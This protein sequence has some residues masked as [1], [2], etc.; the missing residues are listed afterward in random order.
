MIA[1]V[2]ENVIL[3]T[4]EF[5]GKIL[6]DLDKLLLSKLSF[7]QVYF[8]VKS[9]VC[10]LRINNYNSALIRICGYDTKAIFLVTDINKSV[11]FISTP[12]W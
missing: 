4:R 11:Y 6:E 8:P 12:V 5:L 2:T 1:V 10:T 9:V 3:S 7:S